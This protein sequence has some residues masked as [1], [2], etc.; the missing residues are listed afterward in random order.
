MTDTVIAVTLLWSFVFIYSVA[1]SID[2]GAGF[3]SM[4]YQNRE[5]TKA[6]Q[7]ANRYLSPSW[8]VTNVFIVLIVVAMVSFFP[9]ATHTLSAVLLVP[10]SIAVLLL[11][12]RSAF[13][14]YSH[15][16]GG[17]RKMMSAVSGITGIL[18][19][20]LLISVLPI[21]QGGFIDVTGG[22]EQLLYLRVVT[23][24]HVYAFMALAVTST[25]FLSSLLLADYSRASNQHESFR[26]YRRDALIV[27][28]LTLLA[29][30]LTL[31]TMHLE[32][33]WLY[34]RLLDYRNWFIGSALFYFLGYLA[35]A[36]TYKKEWRA[37]NLPRL[38][39]VS[40]VTQYFLASYAYGAAHLPYLIYP[41][42]TVESA[43]THPDTFRALFITYI[44]GFAILAPG[45]IWFWRLFL[46]DRRYLEG[47][48]N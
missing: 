9:G 48:K 41:H 45:F 19:P 43:F 10:G 2:F 6:T 21:S 35:M 40:I 37:I 24:S 36:A 14:V 44:I 18:I 38:A 33:P 46:K 20:A 27:G 30:L 28:P 7:I 32:A 17:Y 23:S 39:M 42:I 8:E 12:I 22:M 4:V 11:L 29:A 5:Q 3:W 34:E 15:L 1:A 13:L 47:Q 25:L 16:V 31:Q 26:I